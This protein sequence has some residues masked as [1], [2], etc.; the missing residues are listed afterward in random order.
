MFIWF[1]CRNGIK[2]TVEVDDVAPREADGATAAACTFWKI[3]ASAKVWEDDKT[4]ESCKVVWPCHSCPPSPSSSCPPSPSWPLPPFPWLQ[5]PSCSWDSHC[6]QRYFPFLK[7]KI[8]RPRKPIDSV[9]PS[10]LPK[11]NFL[12]HGNS[13]KQ[14]VWDRC[15]TMLL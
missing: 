11:W 5:Q 15:S 9:T 13:S 6:S 4:R 2:L 7:N 12:F 1:S 8:H 10:S 14:H 3:E